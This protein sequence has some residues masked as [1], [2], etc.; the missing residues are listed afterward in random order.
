MI[1]VFAA[2]DEDYGK[3]KEI[4]VRKVDEKIQTTAKKPK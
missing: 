4:E 3:K 2:I 1:E